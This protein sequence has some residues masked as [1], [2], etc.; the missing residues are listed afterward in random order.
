MVNIGQYI[1]QYKRLMV[2]LQNCSADLQ[3]NIFQW[4][5]YLF[6]VFLTY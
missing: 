4:D 1:L 5:F 3:W 6:L 2:N